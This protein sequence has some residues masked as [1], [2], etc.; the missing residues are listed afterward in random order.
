MARRV[1]SAHN[2]PTAKFSF[3]SL[4]RGSNK[5]II[6]YQRRSNKRDWYY[7]HR[8]PEGQKSYS[9]TKPIQAKEFEPIKSW[10]NNRTESDISWKVSI[11]DIKAKNWDID[12]KNPSNVENEMEYTTKELIT[13][14]ETSFD[15]SKQ[16]LKSLQ[17]EL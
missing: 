1:Q 5:F 9:K 11:A 2:N 6:L 17:S 3:F 15:E 4:C 7:E 16:I 13:R 12:I 14:L 10:W 8:L